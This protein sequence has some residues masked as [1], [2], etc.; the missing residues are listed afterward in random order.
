MVKEISLLFLIMISLIRCN[1]F[2]AENMNGIY[3][4]INILK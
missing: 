1:K 4:K 2:L 3:Y